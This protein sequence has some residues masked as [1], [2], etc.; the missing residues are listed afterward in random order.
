MGLAQPIGPERRDPAPVHHPPVFLPR[1]RSKAG[2]FIALAIVVVAVAA[3]LVLYLRPPTVVTAPVIRGTA[4]QAVYAT[5]YVETASRVTVRSKIA[6]PVA[7]LNVREGD[8]VSKGDVIAIIDNP[9][10]KYDLEQGKVE[11]WAASK[12]AVAGPRLAAID[13]Q[14]ASIRTDLEIARKERDRIRDLVTSGSAPQADLERAEARVGS[15]DAQLRSLYARSSAERIDLTARARGTTAQVDLLTAKLEDTRVRAPIDG[16]VLSRAVEPGEVVAVDQPIVRI[17]DTNNFLLESSV[18]ESD[19]NRVR[20]GSQAAVSLYAYSGHALRATVTDILPDADRARKSFIVKLKLD[21]PLEGLRT[22]M[23]GEVNIIVDEHARA[24][25]A[26]SESIDSSGVAW[27]VRDGRA[28]RRPVRTGIHDLLKV[29]VLEGLSEGD[30]V[31]VSGADHVS[32]H[33]RVSATGK[34][35]AGA[36]SAAAAPR[37][38]V[39]TPTPAPP[40]APVALAPLPEKPL[41]EKLVADKTATAEPAPADSTTAASDPEP[42]EALKPRLPPTMGLILP[43]PSARGHRILVDN[44]WAGDGTD[45]IRWSCGAHNV[46]IGHHGAPRKVVIPCGGSVSLEDKP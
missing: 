44:M 19:I 20:V 25:L 10:L 11:A 17:G 9:T 5:A 40:T 43:P 8:H 46:A 35:P 4:V 3:A 45:P 32:D 37:P 31:I 6:G 14:A 33:A 41:T 16:T 28:V 13:S 7:A 26:P 29:E 34:A 18:D 21:A 12:Q 36:A 27:I 23:T 30:Q 39:A 1:K 38:S 15:L 24:L 2:L 22:G 42:A